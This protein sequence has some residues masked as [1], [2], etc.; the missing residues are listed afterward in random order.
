MGAKR[1]QS[2]S[3]VC[4]GETMVVLGLLLVLNSTSNKEAKE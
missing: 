4:G 1:R 3:R 2:A